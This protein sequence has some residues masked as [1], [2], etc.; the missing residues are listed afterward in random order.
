MPSCARA[1]VAGY[2]A[3]QRES[4]SDRI[5]SETLMPPIAVAERIK[6]SF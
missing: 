1:L 4:V 5:R 6:L 3:T 2:T